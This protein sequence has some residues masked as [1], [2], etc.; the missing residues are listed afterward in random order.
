[1]SDP[2]LSW[3][4]PTKESVGVGPI[5]VRSDPPAEP[6]PPAPEPEEPE[7]EEPEPEVEP[8]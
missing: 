2:S 1:M 5:V 3:I 8:A 7:P 4:Q 6:E